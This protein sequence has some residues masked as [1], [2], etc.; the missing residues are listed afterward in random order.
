VFKPAAWQ[1]AVVKKQGQTGRGVPD[2]SGDADP[3]TGYR[4]LVDGSWQSIGGTSAVAPLWAGLI[5]VCNQAG[6]KRP[7]DLAAPR[8]KALLAAAW[9]G[10]KS[11][12][13]RKKRRSGRRS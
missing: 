1:A 6:G 5:A 8:G 2:V 11:A 7:A 3:E 9:G 13:G 12:K 4:I 10:A